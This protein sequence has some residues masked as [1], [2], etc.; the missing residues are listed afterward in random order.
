MALI[1]FYVRNQKL[2]KAA[3][4]IISDTVR[5]IDC[6]FTFKTEDWAELDKWVTI[7]NGKEVY[8]VNLVN[9]AIPK[10]T[11]LNLGKGTWT[12]SLFGNG[13]DGS[14]VTTNS[15]TVEVEES[16]IEEGGPLPVIER[17]EAE[18][19]AAKSQEALDRAMAVEQAA[20]NGDFNG[21]PGPQGP[22]GEQGLPGVQGPAGETGPQGPQGLQGEKGEQGETGPQGEIGP[23]G[24]QGKAFTYSDFT[25]EQLAALKGPKG[26]IGPQGETGPQGPEGPQGPK[27]DSGISEE[28]WQEVVN[29]ANE[30]N[31][32][33]A[34]AMN[35]AIVA[36]NM[37]L[38]VESQT[39]NYRR[40]QNVS[41]EEKARARGN[42]GAASVDDLNT[43]LEEAKES[44]EFKGDKG[45]KGDTGAAGYTPV[46]GTD[47][48]TDADKAEMVNLV[49]AAL[50]NG[51]EVSY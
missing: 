46:K 51:D 43:A 17:S 2:S 41:E 31:T 28:E 20:A 21:K 3:P 1:D 35:A 13:A 19:I 37:V 32:N 7:K 47:Y 45:D 9:D 12:V 6:S 16:G 4:K 8:S 18:Q 48:F 44:G 24:P 40:K 34:D 42:I 10:E 5:Y 27:G 38:T 36:Q 39:V 30:A 50:P 26:D 49:L 25:E 15:V 29:T 22:Q 23:E 14:R 33:A 11:G